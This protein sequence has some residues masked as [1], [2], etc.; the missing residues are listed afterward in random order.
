MK[1][2]CILSD[3]DGTITNKDGLY[4]FIKAYAIGNWKEIEQLWANNKITSKECLIE[5]FKLIPN[6]SKDLIDTF[7]ETGI[8]IDTNFKPFYEY[9]TQKNIDFYIVS[10][11]LDYFI[12]RLLNKYKLNRK[13]VTNHGEFKD[14]KFEITFPNDS[15]N[16]TKNAGTC[17]CKVVSD[18]RKKYKKVVYIGDG[19]SDFCVADKADILFAKSKL[20]QHAAS[21]GIPYIPFEN[22]ND[23]L[24]EIKVFTN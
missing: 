20:I 18:M 21:K 14:G 13:T 6:L 22:F 17:K 9:I 15:S 10:D 11:G 19:V 2:L 5:E 12:E 16:C 24:N 3:F 8:D 7:V 1:E 23:I 4:S